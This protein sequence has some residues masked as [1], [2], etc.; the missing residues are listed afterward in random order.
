MLIESASNSDTMI[1]SMRDM[2][3]AAPMLAASRFTAVRN[4][5]CKQKSRIALVARSG[6]PSAFRNKSAYCF[7]TCSA[8][9]DA[10]PT[11]EPAAE[12]APQ[13]PPSARIR[14]TVATACVPCKWLACSCDVSTC[15]S[16]SITSR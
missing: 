16:P 15:R 14:F 5:N 7:A 6:F 9:G 10:E 2:P 8:D 11:V 12:A 13:P 4:K 1:V 3:I